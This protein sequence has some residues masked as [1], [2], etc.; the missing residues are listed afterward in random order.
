MIRPQHL[1]DLVVA[2]AL[3]QVPELWSPSAEMLVL[4]TC[5]HESRMGH[6]LAQTPIGPALG[7]FQMEPPTFLD[8]WRWLSRRLPLKEAAITLAG[9][10]PCAEDMVY[11]LRFAAYMARIHYWRRPEALPEAGDMKG[12]WRYYKRYYNTR[13]G[14]ARE[15]DFM[16]AF[17]RYVA[18][19]YIGEGIQLS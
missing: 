4:G 5:A 18:P 14:A 3:S 19:L 13:L 1:K 8:N 6:F 9:P 2:P 15:E 17:H 16:E 7:I 12:M 10:E 11:N